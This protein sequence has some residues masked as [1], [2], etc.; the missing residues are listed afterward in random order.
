MF[1][2]KSANYRSP[3]L[4]VLSSPETQNMQLAAASSHVFRAAAGGFPLLREPVP[5]LHYLSAGRDGVV[6]L[7]FFAQ[8]AIF[9]LT[10]LIR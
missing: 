1:N 2:S 5:V 8:I 10:M 7:L 3:L 4:Y 9:P 6:L